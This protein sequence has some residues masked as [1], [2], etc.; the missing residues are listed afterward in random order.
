MWLPHVVDLLLGKK[1]L[2][3]NIFVNLQWIHVDK[4]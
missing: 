3:G 2:H 1:I 4:F